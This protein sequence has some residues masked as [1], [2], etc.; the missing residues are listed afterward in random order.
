MLAAKIARISLAC[1]PVDVG[2]LHRLLK[3]LFFLLLRTRTPSGIAPDAEKR[4]FVARSALIQPD[5]LGV[6]TG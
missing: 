5:A 4:G 1:V 6:R 3:P 2:S